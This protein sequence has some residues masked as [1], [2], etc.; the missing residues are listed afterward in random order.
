MIF[1]TSKD[2]DNYLIVK[3][4][5][6]RRNVIE[7]MKNDIREL[8]RGIRTFHYYGTDLKKIDS[9]C[10][11]KDE[12]ERIN[13]K[14]YT[15]LG[16]GEGL[17]YTGLDVP[18]QETLPVPKQIE[19]YSY[20]S[21]YKSYHQWYFEETITNV[22]F[23][24][25]AALLL[26]GVWG[27]INC[28]ACL[29]SI[30][31]DYSN[32]ATILEQP[33]FKNTAVILPESVYTGKFNPLAGIIICSVAFFPTLVGAM[34][35]AAS[36]LI[37]GAITGG[38]SPLRDFAFVLTG[39]SIQAIWGLINCILIL[40]GLVQ[41]WSWIDLA[42][43]LPY[44]SF[45]RAVSGVNLFPELSQSI[46]YVSFANIVPF[47]FIYIFICLTYFVII[48]LFHCPKK[49]KESYQYQEEQAAKIDA[50]I[51]KINKQNEYIL[52][53]RK[54]KQLDEINAR[55]RKQFEI[56][57]KYAPLFY[58]NIWKL[59]DAQKLKKELE[60][61]VF[62]LMKEDEESMAKC[63]LHKKYKDDVVAL[64]SFIDYFETGRCS[65]FEGP[66]GVIDCYETDVYRQKVISGFDKIDEGLAGLAGQL[67]SIALQQATL[68]QSISD[69]QRSIDA[70]SREI[71]ACFDT[72]SY[73]VDQLSTAVYSIPSPTI[74]GTI[75]SSDGHII[76]SIS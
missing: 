60:Q 71:A 32:L 40:K 67:S 61:K 57:K 47:V 1:Q 63:T 12:K 75:Y 58:Q 51:A 9:R 76:A 54:Q 30:I 50:E 46:G 14:N 48:P 24:L 55:K 31:K 26:L 38:H 28:V 34:F 2:K 69:V 33:Y 6:S 29:A 35:I 53:T 18:L 22:A 74:S 11:G 13:T 56:A 70:S 43:D 65:T 59:S 25:G 20:K 62:A 15:A 66:G 64:S 27:L 7:R 49:A 23:L 37:E 21:W 41:N 8:T 52:Q 39:I 17:S 44:F 72:M 42:F 10:I 4:H 73:K 68:A 16:N 19:K 3:A 45:F 36:I 5:L